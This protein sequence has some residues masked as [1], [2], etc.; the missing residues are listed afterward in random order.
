MKSFV[1]VFGLAV[2]TG[3]VP[4]C[5]SA[6]NF[7]QGNSSSIGT[8][9]APSDSGSSGGDSL[10]VNANP[11]VGAA[12]ASKFYQDNSLSGSPPSTNVSTPSN[13]DSATAPTGALGGGDNSAQNWATS[14]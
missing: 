13:D 5:A 7:L 10:G 4:I 6:Q 8:F 1:I 14:P 12:G 3:L 2:G 9:A 11:F